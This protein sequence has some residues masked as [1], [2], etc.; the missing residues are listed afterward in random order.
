MANFQFLKNARN[1]GYTLRLGSIRLFNVSSICKNKL[2]G[3]THKVNNLEKKFLVWTGKFKTVE[4]IPTYLPPDVVDRARNRM[5]IRLAN[6]MMAVTLIAC[7]FVS[8][9]GKRAHERG[10]SLQ[11]KTI[12][13]HK[14]L[15]EEQ[16]EKNKSQ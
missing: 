8:I 13:W 1:L 7:L 14:Q 6:I 16:K 5:R 11:Q 15:Q 12:D 10:E 2:S 4:E 3:N 9:S